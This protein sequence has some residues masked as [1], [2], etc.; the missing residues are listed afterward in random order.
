MSGIYGVGLSVSARFR[1]AICRPG[2]AVASKRTS[3]AGPKKVARMKQ[4]E[5]R[6]WE[7]WGS[8]RE[9][10]GVPVASARTSGAGPETESGSALGVVWEDVEAL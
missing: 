1:P 9:A 10:L 5:A 8:S 3:G 2:M 6:I 7:D 4:D